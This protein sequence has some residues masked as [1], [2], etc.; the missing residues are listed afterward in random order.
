MAATTQIE[1]LTVEYILS[2][3][4]DVKLD[5]ANDLISLR[6]PIE[7]PITCQL[8]TKA[9]MIAFLDKYRVYLKALTYDRN[10]PV[11]IYRRVDEGVYKLI[12]TYKSL[13]SLIECITYYIDSLGLDS[14]ILICDGCK[15][16]MSREVYRVKEIAALKDELAS[17]KAK[18]AEEKAEAD[19]KLADLTAKLK[20]A[21]DEKAA[22]IEATKAT[23]IE[24]M[25]QLIK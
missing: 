22:A 16:T 19:A 23:F 3:Y 15:H 14:I 4:G 20:L 24:A 8:H 1:Y 13:I 9:S 6:V 18:L 17:T 12:N 21:D 25:K 7:E 10:A 2:R 11:G 5:T